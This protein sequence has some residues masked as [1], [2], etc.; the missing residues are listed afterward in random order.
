[1]AAFLREAARIKKTA[2]PGA[3]HAFASL[4]WERDVI[5][6]TVKRFQRHLTDS[7]RAARLGLPRPTRRIHSTHGMFYGFGAALGWAGARRTR[8]PLNSGTMLRMGLAGWACVRIA[9]LN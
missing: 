1:M 5:Q 7:R 2:I 8:L 3:D 6:H 4:T 9:V